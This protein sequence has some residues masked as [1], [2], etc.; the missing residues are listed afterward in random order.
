MSVK[1]AVP[2]MLAFFT[3][4]AFF[5]RPVGVM[6]AI[7]RCPNTN[8]P[9]PPGEYL[10]KKGFGSY[11]RQVCGM[12]YDYTLLTEKLT[13]PHCHKM[14]Q[15]MSQAHADNREDEEEDAHN[16]Q[17]YTWL[18][19][20]PKILMNLAPAV[21]SMFPAILSRD[22]S[23]YKYNYC[24]SSHNIGHHSSPYHDYYFHSCPHQDDSYHATPHHGRS[25]HDH[26]DH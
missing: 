10:E 6:K 19:Y 17:Q 7:I 22:Y 20:S 16:A 12:K 15:T 4:P 8:C 2:N 14:R 13:C 11:A 9:A 23:T 21:R 5:W 3:T 26:H 18:T 1:G 24:C 25:L